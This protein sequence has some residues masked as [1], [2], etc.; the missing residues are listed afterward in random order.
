[1]ASQFEVETM[2]KIV[3]LKAELIFDKNNEALKDYLN[4]LI[5]DL[6]D[7]LKEEFV[8]QVEVEVTHSAPK[9]ERYQLI[10]KAMNL[11]AQCPMAKIYKAKIGRG[12]IRA[13]KAL[14]PNR[15]LGF[16]N[17]SD[18]ILGVIRALPVAK[19]HKGNKL[20]P[21]I[22][23][24]IITSMDM[25]SSKAIEYKYGFSS[26]ISEVYMKA[27]KVA[28]Q[29]LHSFERRGEF[30]EGGLEKALEGMEGMRNGN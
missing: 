25:V 8:E 22:L 28:E 30:G 12:D 15:V 1:M 17:N 27:F 14:V 24:D 7:F 26:S 6:N 21:V 9:F 19:T 10:K 13:N 29:M 23:Q 3:Q 4:S 16:T 11:K 20:L 2:S 5:E 18:V